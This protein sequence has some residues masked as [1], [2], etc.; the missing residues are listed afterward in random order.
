MS[1]IIKNMNEIQLTFILPTYNRSQMVDENLKRLSELSKVFDFKV[2]V[3]NNGS[4][5]DTRNVLEKWSSQMDN[6]QVIHQD[7]NVFYDRNVTSGYMN[8][9]TPYCWV[10]GDSRTI[11]A[12][13]LSEMI[14]TLRKSEPDALIIN[15]ESRNLGQ[16]P[17]QYNDCREFLREWG[18]YTT[19][20]CSA[21][22]KAS[23]LNYER[24][25]RFFDT[26]F[27]HF[28]VLFDLLAVPE[29]VNIMLAPCIHITA[30]TVG[31]KSSNTWGRTP[32]IYFVNRWFSVVMQLPN[33]YTLE[34]K[35]YCLKQ[36]DRH[37]K[38]FSPVNL[39]KGRLS[40]MTFEDYPGGRSLMK[41]VID[42]PV[43]VVDFIRCIP[44][45]PKLY[46][47]LRKTF[48]K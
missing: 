36:H 30:I 20:L 21:V 15:D 5:D 16:K 2:I 45:M 14:E 17:I 33:K 48:K 39:I 1:N 10:I 42:Y 6:L 9:Q 23:Y 26:H 47:F 25:Q 41:F 18:W 11:E 29:T 7:K 28:G 27:E 13:C 37:Q 3:C 31:N 19:L 24:C 38:L 8:V 12:E 44:T 34:D 46:Q 32:F 35:L 43:I 4:T 40:G 22:I